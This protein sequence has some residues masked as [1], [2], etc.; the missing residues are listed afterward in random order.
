MA[1]PPIKITPSPNTQNATKSPP[2]LAFSTLSDG[3]SL[4]HFRHRCCVVMVYLPVHIFV[5]VRVQ[6]WELSA[7]GWPFGPLF[8]P[9]WFSFWLLCLPWASAG[10]PLSESFSAS[11]TAL[12][13][14]FF[15]FSISQHN[16]IFGVISAFSHLPYFSAVFWWGF[17]EMKL[18]P[19]KWPLRQPSGFLL[20]HI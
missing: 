8:W 17:W 18:Y 5:V 16:I 10:A 7:A 11:F 13:T 4:P 2:V 6:S 15:L 1:H 12:F 9:E 19:V 3:F 14:F 20:M